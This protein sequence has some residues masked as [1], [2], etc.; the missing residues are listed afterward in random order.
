MFTKALAESIF[1]VALLLD[2]EDFFVVKS[3]AIE[4]NWAVDV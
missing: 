2:P 3:D 1:V 4:I